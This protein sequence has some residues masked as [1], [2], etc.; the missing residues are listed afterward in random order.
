M[1]D[2]MEDCAKL[3]LDSDSNIKTAD[4]ML[5]VTYPLL[6]DPR[7]IV[8]IIER[9][10]ASL[11][12]SISSVLAYEHMFKR[13][14]YI[15]QKDEEKVMVFKEWV[16]KTYAFDRNM[17]LILKELKEFVDFGRKSPLT[18]VRKEKYVVCSSGYNTKTIDVK[19]I[20]YYMEQS[21]IFVKKAQGIL[22]NGL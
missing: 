22:K 13:L 3:M 14:E 11:M 6:N 7:L 19:R 17:I 20:K 18:F 21:K 9:L 4:H 8:T 10:Y 1:A 12:S 2:I 5:Q 15:P 16:M